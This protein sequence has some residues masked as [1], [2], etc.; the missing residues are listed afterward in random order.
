MDVKYE[1]QEKKKKIGES[2]KYSN[3]DRDEG[4]EESDL[5]GPVSATAPVSTK[6]SVDDGVADT[7]VDG[8]P[9]GTADEELV[10]RAKEK[11][12]GGWVWGWCLNRQNQEARTRTRTRT[13]TFLFFK[14]FSS[15][16]LFLLP[17]ILFVIVS[18]NI[19]VSYGIE[20]LTSM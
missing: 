18:Y 10:L 9:I 20:R 17:K 16:V 7:I 8:L 13:S 4:N 2:Q 14:V 15:L 19:I 6:D 1:H 5:D 11:A 12:D 3:R